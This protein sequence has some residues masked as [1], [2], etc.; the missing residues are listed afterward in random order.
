[1]HLGW[2]HFRFVHKFE[3]LEIAKQTNI[4]TKILYCINEYQNVFNKMKACA[5]PRIYP[6]NQKVCKEK[7]CFENPPYRILNRHCHFKIGFTIWRLHI[8]L[9]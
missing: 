1:M 4:Y 7:Y 6:T 9:T 2:H 5:D 3:I 8:T